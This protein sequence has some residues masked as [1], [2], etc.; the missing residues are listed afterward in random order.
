MPD[1][2]RIAFL[3]EFLTSFIW[4]KIDL[5]SFCTPLLSIYVVFYRLSIRCVVPGIKEGGGGCHPPRVLSWPGTPSA[6]GRNE[7]FVWMK[8]LRRYL[9]IVFCL[10]NDIPVLSGSIPWVSPPSFDLGTRKWIRLKKRKPL[11]FDYS[12]WNVS[13]KKKTLRQGTVPL[14]PPSILPSAP[15]HNSL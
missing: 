1:V 15:M 11:Y 10:K 14:V 5:S 6:R 7:W 13:Q 3:G 12:F 9:H 4:P 8:T 2:L